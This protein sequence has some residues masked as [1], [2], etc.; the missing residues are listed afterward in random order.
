MYASN[1]CKRTA[2][3]RPLTIQS[4]EFSGDWASVQR[5]VGYISVCSMVALIGKCIRKNRW[6]GGIINSGF[7]RSCG[8]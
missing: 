8:S 6:I 3:L 7:L 2:N 5:F 4:S 1:A